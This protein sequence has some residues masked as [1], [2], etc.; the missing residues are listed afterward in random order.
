MMCTLFSIS[1]IE[2]ATYITIVQGNVKR[3]R[4][5]NIKLSV[6]KSSEFNLVVSLWLGMFTSADFDIDILL[7]ING[8]GT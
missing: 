7:H 1:L 4:G 6:L 8:G 2:V 3:L 5:A